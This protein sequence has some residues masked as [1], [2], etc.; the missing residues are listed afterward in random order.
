MICSR[1]DTGLLVAENG[2][3]D[4]KAIARALR[5]HDPDLRLV[6]QG[7]RNGMT[8]YKVYRYCGSERPAEFICFWGN[9]QG[10]PYPL[11][12][13]LLDKVRALDKSQRGSE[14]YLS[15]DELNDRAKAAR[16]EQAQADA[17]DLFDDWKT[18]EKRSACLPRSTSLARARSRTGYHDSK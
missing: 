7:F 13:R 12:S 8:A 18:R 15:E 16:Q 1:S 2:S 5:D 17:E 3:A 9:A 14:G 10:E 11:S 6:P 4:E